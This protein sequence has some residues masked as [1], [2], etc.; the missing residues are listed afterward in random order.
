[1]DRRRR[2]AITFVGKVIYYASTLA[3]AWSAVYY[4]HVFGS[5]VAEFL[6]VYA[7]LLFVMFFAHEA[8]RRKGGFFHRS[9]PPPHVVAV[10]LI[11]MWVGCWLGLLIPRP[12][13]VRTAIGTVMLEVVLEYVMALVRPQRQARRYSTAHLSGMSVHALDVADKPANN[14]A[15]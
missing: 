5:T 2:P 10:V 8:L 1:M 9:Q 7:A 12:E 6:T 15:N 11:C 4:G 13:Y 3:L 14:D